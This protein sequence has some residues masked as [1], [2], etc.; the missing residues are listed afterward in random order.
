MWSGLATDPASVEPC[1]YHY[2]VACTP[3]S[4]SGTSLVIQL[5][6]PLLLNLSLLQSWVP[7]PW[8]PWTCQWLLSADRRLQQLRPLPPRSSGWAAVLLPCPF[9]P[10]RDFN[11]VIILTSFPN[12]P[13]QEVFPNFDWR[14]GECVWKL[15]WPACLS[16]L[17]Q[18]SC[19][20]TLG[21]PA[22]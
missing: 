4:L 22:S 17:W 20:V 5:Q 10:S 14:K 1:A 19:L 18:L 21:Q 8:V 11:L 15:L 12:S 13:D 16:V 6:L 7:Y 3:P 9:L 2:L